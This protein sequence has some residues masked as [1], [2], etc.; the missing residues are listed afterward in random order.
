MKVKPAHV[1][2]HCSLFLHGEGALPLPRTR[3]SYDDPLPPHARAFRLQAAPA[4]RKGPDMDVGRGKRE[5]SRRRLRMRMA[6]WFTGGVFTMVMAGMSLAQGSLPTPQTANGV[7]Y[8]TGGFGDDMAQAFK[9]AESAYPLALTFAEDAGGGSRP[10]VAEVDVSIKD[11]SGATVLEVPSTGPYFLAKLKP[12]KYRVEATYM[13]K[14][15]TQNVTV[16][17]GGA[18]RHV[19][20]WKSP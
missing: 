4:V 1:T 14:T 10:Y 19:I 20:T 11:Q 12:G 17:E 5:S 3:A 6:L 15:Q 16:G 8:V 13:G 9:A 2:P 7:E 18:S